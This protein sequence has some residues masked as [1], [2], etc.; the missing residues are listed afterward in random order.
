MHCASASLCWCSQRAKRSQIGLPNGVTGRTLVS[1]TQQL[2]LTLSLVRVGFF[3]DS[4]QDTFFTVHLTI[5]YT[6]LKLIFS[7]NATKPL[8]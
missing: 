7:E 3:G 4:K 5:T 6:L 2:Y 8:V 1:E